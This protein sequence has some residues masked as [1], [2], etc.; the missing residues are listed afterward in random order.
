M[1]SFPSDKSTSVDDGSESAATER[2][3]KSQ[4]KRDMT[5]LQDLGAELVALAPEPLRRL[6]LPDELRQAIEAARRITAHEGRR[7]Q[8]QYVGKL[9]RRVD[10]EPIRAALEMLSGKSRAATE[11]LHR[12]ERWRDRLLDDDAALTEWLAAHQD[13]DVQRLRALI[14][15]A[16]RER[17]TAAAP[18]SARELY[19]L[20]KAVLESDA[21]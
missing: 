5:A 18:K 11:L 9:M 15:A 19:R 17:A 20:L 2:P 21:A 16:R 10:P 13:G 8:L 4:R 1:S 14:R 7:R 12:C 6:E 3:S